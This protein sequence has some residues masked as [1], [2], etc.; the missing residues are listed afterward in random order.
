M[1]TA[2]DYTGR[3]CTRKRTRDRPSGARWAPRTPGTRRP[4]HSRTMCSSHCTP[5]ARA[6]LAGSRNPTDTPPAGSSWPHSTGPMRTR[7]AQ[8]KKKIGVKNGDCKLIC[9]TRP[10]IFCLVVNGNDGQ[11]ECYS[12]WLL[13]TASLTRVPASA[14]SSCPCNS[15]RRGK[16]RSARKAMHSHSR[17]QACTAAR[18]TC[19]RRA[20][21]NR[22]ATRR[23]H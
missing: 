3:S 20:Q 13:S 12:W 8:M 15:G 14:S 19:P 22:P 7:A 2:C 16:C 4:C 23:T 11:H 6:S 5:A 21:T 18:P 17:R 1:H 9:D 10:D